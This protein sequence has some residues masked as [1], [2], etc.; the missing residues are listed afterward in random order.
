MTLRQAWPLGQAGKEVPRDGG[1][2]ATDV[3]MKEVPREGSLTG[4]DRGSGFP[5]GGERGNQKEGAGKQGEGGKRMEALILL[6]PIL[7]PHI[8]GIPIH[9]VDGNIS[10]THQLSVCFCL[11]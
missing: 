10:T 11:W 3:P 6:T 8:G 5:K 2:K 7:K 1:A 9:A 4:R